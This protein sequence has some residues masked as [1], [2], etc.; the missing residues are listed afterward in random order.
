MPTAP[1][2]KVIDLLPESATALQSAKKVPFGL[3][4]LGE[5]INDSVK[6]AL[7]PL[8]YVNFI[9]K[10]VINPIESSRVNSQALIG[11]G[12]ENRDNT[13]L[14]NKSTLNS[15][16]NVCFTNDLQRNVISNIMQI[17][18]LEKDESFVEED[19]FPIEDSD[20]AF[21]IPKLTAKYANREE[22]DFSDEDEIDKLAENVD[23]LSD[24]T[25]EDE[26][27]SDKEKQKNATSFT[28]RTVKTN[29]NMGELLSKDNKPSIEI[30]CIFK[31][32]DD[33]RQDSLALQIISVFKEIFDQSNLGL[34][35][36]PYKTISTITGKHKDLGGFIET[37]PNCDSRDQIGKT[38]DTDLYEYFKFT[39]G[40]ENSNEFRKA[41]KNFIESQA[42]YSVISY[43]LQIKDRHNGNIMIDNMGHLIHIDFGFIFD[44]SPG[45]NI[46]F[47]KAAFKMTKEMVMIIGDV[48]TESYDYFVDLSIKAFLACRDYVDKLMDPI[49]LMFNSGLEC[50]RENSL[51]NYLDRFKLN[52]TEVDATVYFKKLIDEANGN[53]RTNFYD[54]IQKKQNNIYY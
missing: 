20:F 5:R 44:I 24:C 38:Y 49:I 28:R 4:F 46:G 8:N 35:V 31:V 30:Q 34:Y 9:K 51:D 7:R 16:F 48:G 53:W 2:I 15:Y 19:I 43:I 6:T 10:I 13:K 52:L 50:F 17:Q 41:R 47:E 42:A 23:N 21:K 29:T 27:F 54:Y 11:A 26:N 33:L 32:G 12:Y 3:T 36:C 18:K 22:K 1:E 14:F 40:H 25:I 39:F 37:V 45:G